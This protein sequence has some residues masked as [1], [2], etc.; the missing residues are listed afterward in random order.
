MSRSLLLLT[1][2][3]PL[4]WSKWP[5]PAHL[6]YSGVSL[7]SS[8]TSCCF[9]T[10]FS[11]FLMPELDVRSYFSWPKPLNGVL[12]PTQE[13]AQVLRLPSAIWAP[14][15]S[16]IYSSYSIPS[17]LAVLSKGLPHPSHEWPY[18]SGPF[19]KC[20][21]SRVSCLRHLY[22]SNTHRSSYFITST[23]D[24]WLVYF[25]TLFIVYLL[26]CPPAYK[27]PQ[28]RNFCLFGSCYNSRKLGGCQRKK[29]AWFINESMD[30]EQRGRRTGH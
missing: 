30:L 18:L 27:P 20:P 23:T 1:S 3:T 19:L 15:L 26:T 17:S 11:L 22:I 10:S 9:C 4:S 2:F 21:T 12:S 25:F 24:R 14:C 7:L 6:D 28:D 29:G 8:F 13:K 16:H 5:S